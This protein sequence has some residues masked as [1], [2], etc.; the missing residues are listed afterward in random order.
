M[1]VS[2]QNGFRGIVTEDKSIPAIREISASRITLR[3]PK[4]VVLGQYII[5]ARSF[6]VVTVELMDGTRGVSFSLDRGTPVADSINTLIAEPYKEIFNGNPVATFD[7]L[8]HKMSAPLSSGASIKG[9]SLVDLASHDAVARH[10]NLTVVANY[11]KKSQNHPI[12]GVIGYPPSR[13]PEEIASEVVAAVQSGV[14][15]VK[16]PVGANPRLTRE[17]LEA[18]LATKL[19]P[20]SVDLAWSC[21]TAQDALDIVKGLNLAWVEDPFIPGSIQELIELRSKLDVPLASGDDETHLYHPQVFVETRALDIL[22]MDATCQGGLSRMLLLNDY[23]ANSGLAISWHVYAPIH[24]QIA[25]ILDAPTFSIEVSSPGA[26]V[27]PLAELIVEEA[28][29]R[30]AREMSGW[31]FSLPELPEISNALDGPPRWSTAVTKVSG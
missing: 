16:L 22:R 2:L 28:S 20:V 10:K 29:K 17:R 9:L 31:M 24:H 18:A 19:C 30:G 8:I 27:D 15:G 11:G 3:L 4:P 21:R 14:A 7:S 26:G 25:S 5:K 12:W 13:G 6:A 23:L 1:A